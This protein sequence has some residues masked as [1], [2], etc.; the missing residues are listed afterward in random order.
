MLST[1]LSQIVRYT[2]NQIVKVPSIS[3]V[4]LV[5][6]GLKNV[7]VKNDKLNLV[8]VLHDIIIKIQLELLDLSQTIYF[9]FQIFFCDR[10]KVDKFQY[11][12][13]PLVH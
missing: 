13:S 9:D 5:I 7:Y 4:L 3:F 12:I 6:S 11:P 2:G 10:S 8:V 1:L